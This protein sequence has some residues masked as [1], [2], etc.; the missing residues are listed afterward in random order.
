MTG[1]E[2]NELLVDWAKYLGMIRKDPKKANHEEL[3]AL[4]KRFENVL[5]DD[6]AR[7]GD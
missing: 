2:R 6:F 1:E 5:M 4:A 3:M 7:G